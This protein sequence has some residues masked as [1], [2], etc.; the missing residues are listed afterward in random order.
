MF[1]YMKCSKKVKQLTF[2]DIFLVIK[3]TVENN[4][5]KIIDKPSN[6]TELNE[7]LF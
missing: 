3:S 1:Y 6:I 5:V 7:K 2:T 4:Y